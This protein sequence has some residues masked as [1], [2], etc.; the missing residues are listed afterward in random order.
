MRSMCLHVISRC[1]RWLAFNVLEY[2]GN[3]SPSA[4]H[5]PP[6]IALSAAGILTQ[7]AMGVFYKPESSVSLVILV[8]ALTSVEAAKPRWR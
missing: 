7:L 2:S 1:C 3:L 6:S 4:V 8:F 5:A